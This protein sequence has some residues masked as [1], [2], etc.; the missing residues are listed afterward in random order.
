M[1]SHDDPRAPGPAH[2]FVAGDFGTVVQASGATLA[3]SRVAFWNDNFGIDTWSSLGAGITGSFGCCAGHDQRVNAVAAFNDD[4]FLGGGFK[5]AG[6]GMC[7]ENNAWG[8]AQWLESDAVGVTEIA[9]TGG[10][11]KN[12]LLPPVPNP[13]SGSTAITYELVLDG[14]V[15]LSIHDVTGRLIETLV[16]GAQTKGP[17]TA[18]WST[19][20]SSGTGVPSSGVYFI[21][22]EALGGTSARRVVVLR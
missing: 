22:L 12:L 18:H 13:A 7:S 6:Y 14:R 5:V 2:L 19:A 21:R 16:D 1:L 3:A 10:R 8:I 20:R 4:L 15:K 9:A 17:H 11:S